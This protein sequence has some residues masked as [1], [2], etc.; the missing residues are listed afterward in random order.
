MKMLLFKRVGIEK[1]KLTVS[2]FHF[3]SSH[4]QVMA[5]CLKD[6]QVIINE[7]NYSIFDQSKLLKH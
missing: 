2:I 5:S 7:A 4:G 1:M 3:S 6:S